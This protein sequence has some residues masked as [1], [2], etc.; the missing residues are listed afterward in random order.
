MALEQEIETYRRELPRLLAEV[1]RFVLIKGSDI[2][3][4]FAT[5]QDAL[6]AGYARFGRVPLLVKEIQPVEEPIRVSDGIFHRCR[7]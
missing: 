1:G 4:T 6:A 7:S 5:R 3:G 2:A